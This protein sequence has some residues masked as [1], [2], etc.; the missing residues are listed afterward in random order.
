MRLQEMRCAVL[1]LG[2]LQ[3]GCS[4]DDEAG[5]ADGAAE[6]ADDGAD[7]TD[8]DGSDESDGEPC[9]G[10]AAGETCNPTSGECE[11]GP[12]TCSCDPGS[13]CDASGACVPDEVCP[14]TLVPG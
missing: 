4:G 12:D 1:V 8:P 10:C 5:D 14:D 6:D 13:H 9:G 3:V 7:A 11:P 2:L